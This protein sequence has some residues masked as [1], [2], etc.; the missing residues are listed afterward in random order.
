MTATLT[1]T[2]HVVLLDPSGRPTGGVPKREAHSAHTRLHLAFSCHVVAPDGRVLTTQRSSTKPT[3]PGIWTNACCGHPQLGETLRRAV[4][5]RLV[6]ELGLTPRRLALALPDFTYRAEMADGTVEHERCP[7]LIA[8]VDGEPAPDPREVDDL[9]WVSWDELTQRAWATPDSLSPW[10]VAQIRDLAR[11]APSPAEWLRGPAASRA[12]A[13]LDVAIEVGA[14]VDPAPLARPAADA[15]TVVAE[16]LAGLLHDFLS[17]KAAQLASID[18]ALAEVTDEI[19]GLV[20]A[21]GKRLRPAFVHWG[22]R[23]TGTDTDPEVLRPAAAVELLHTFAL[24]HDDVMDRSDDRRGR[25]AAHAALGEAHR[26]AGRLG[27]PAWFG[28]SAAILAGDLTFVWADELFDST[29][30]PSDALE[31]ARRVFTALREEVIAGQYLDLL[32]AADR[33]ADEARARHVALLKSARYTVTRPLLLGAALAPG[34]PDGAVVDALRA[35]GDAVGSAFQLR[36]DILGLFGDP[37]ATGKGDLD[38]LHEG[39][40]TLLMLRA[41][42]LADP[43]E[44]SVLMAALGNRDLDERGADAVRTVVADTGALSSV[45]ALLAAE[46]LGA[47]EASDSLPEPA[48]GALAELA[49]LA[50]RRFR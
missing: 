30:L 1:A 8:E 4:T 10:A 43:R 14:R 22:H 42:R 3:W 18:P 19:V 36:D 34:H 13:L 45:E 49:D 7:V 44:R 50:I 12:Q 29:A 48:R 28:T 27:D 35:Y 37:A 2:E 24:L 21:G 5:R 15:L 46:H 20:A 17:R 23:A 31:R 33:A 47:L 26:H 9:A 25:P 32:L 38:D 40:R 41:M 16:P 11:L 6:E 39:K